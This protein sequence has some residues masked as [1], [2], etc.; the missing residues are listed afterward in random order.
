MAC[1]ARVS[2]SIVLTLIFALG[3]TLCKRR[4]S[5]FLRQ[6]LWDLLVLQPRMLSAFCTVLDTRLHGP[7]SSGIFLS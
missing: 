6:A 3:A 4:A 2:F 5:H 1:E 7:F